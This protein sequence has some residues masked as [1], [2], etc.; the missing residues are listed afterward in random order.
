MHIMSAKR[1]VSYIYGR[2]QALF[3]KKKKKK[4]KGV[5][6]TVDGSALTNNIHAINLPPPP[7]RPLNPPTATGDFR[8]KYQN[9]SSL[10]TYMGKDPD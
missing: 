3:Y 10:S 5:D 1:E 9:K 7:P 4:K 2:V 6:Q 8:Y